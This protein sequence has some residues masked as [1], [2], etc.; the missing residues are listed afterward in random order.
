MLISI[1]VYTGMPG[2]QNRLNGIIFFF[3]I[4]LSIDN[5]LEFKKKPNNKNVQCAHM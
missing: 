1:P 3:D 4:K 5:V 2:T